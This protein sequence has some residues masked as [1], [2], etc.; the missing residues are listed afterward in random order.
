MCREKLA[1]L[2]DLYPDALVKMSPRRPLLRARIAGTK[3][4]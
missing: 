1:I 3:R 4:W 2:A